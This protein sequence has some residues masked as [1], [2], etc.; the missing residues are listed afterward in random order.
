MQ[1]DGR[2]TVGRPFSLLISYDAPLMKP[3]RPNRIPANGGP[4]PPDP[5][6]QQTIREAQKLIREGKA[7][8]ALTLLVPLEKKSRNDAQLLHL[9]AIGYQAVHHIKKAREYAERSF[10]LQPDPQKLMIAAQCYRVDGQTDDAVHTCD[11]VMEQFPQATPFARVVKAGALEESGRFDEARAT[12]T[13][14]LE[15]DALP[16]H[17][18]NS[19]R[20][21]WAKL[22]VHE[23]KFSEA[24]ALIDELLASEGV[25][26]RYRRSFLHLKAKSCDRAKDFAGAYHAAAA[27]NEIGKL[28]FSAEVYTDQVSMLIENWSR[29]AMTKFPI[30]D[31]QSEVPVFVAG[32]P[33]SGTSLIDQIIDAHPQAAGVGELSDIEIFADALGR[34]YDSDKPPPDCFGPFQNKAFTRIA[35]QYIHHCQKLSPRG[36][37]RVVNKA[38]GNNKLVG[39]LARLFPKCRIIHAMRD[40]RDVSISCFMGGFN[41]RL[42]AWTT[43]IDWAA[44]AWAQ[45]ERMM[46]HWKASLDVPILDVHYE[47]LVADPE[48]QFRRL[49]D[50]IGLPW[51][52]ACLAFHK[53]RRTVRTLSYDQVNRP[54]YTSSSGRHANY[55]P[56]IGGIE[57]PHYDVRGFA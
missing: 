52:D 1:P 48:N 21:E 56:F 20:F 16:Q 32:M 33:R 37:E 50:F 36:T 45:S 6:R 19:A 44:D 8:R 42:H 3:N 57:F 53:S 13:P 49:I 28:D 27:A 39:L 26:A 2:P 40:P 24:N 15:N 55:A 34:G 17:T 11:R 29:E 31:C 7:D 18:R 47:A 23:K 54:I 12:I 25:D 35:A 10:K 46:Q 51:D 4:R 22:L 38:L 9:L 41:N 14:L 43:Q 30:A 5:R